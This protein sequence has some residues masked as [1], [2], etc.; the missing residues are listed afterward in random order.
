MR[1]VMINVCLCG[2][3]LLWPFVVLF[4]VTR[5]EIVESI[6]LYSFIFLITLICALRKKKKFVFFLN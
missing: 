4:H 1:I 2:T 5:I 3:C 6:H